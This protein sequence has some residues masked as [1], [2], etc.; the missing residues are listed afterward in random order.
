MNKRAF[1]LFI[2]LKDSFFVYEGVDKNSK[3]FS[4]KFD[5]CWFLV[6]KFDLCWVMYVTRLVIFVWAVEATRNL[7]YGRALLK[8]PGT[9]TKNKKGTWHKQF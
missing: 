9:L 2:L 5:L 8:V 6:N 4:A 1:L 3:S 7:S